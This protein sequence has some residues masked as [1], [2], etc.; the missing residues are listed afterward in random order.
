MSSPKSALTT[1]TVTGNGLNKLTADLT[2]KPGVDMVAPFGNN[3]HVSGRDEAALESAIAPYRN[4]NEARL[5][6]VGAVAGGRFHRV[7]E[8]FEG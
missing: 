5:A 1:Y 6:Q 7:D 2:D 4:E 3:L 8:P